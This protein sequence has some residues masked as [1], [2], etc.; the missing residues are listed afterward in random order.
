[1]QPI[2]KVNEGKYPMKDL[3]PSKNIIHS[4][5]FL[6]DVSYFYLPNLA[7]LL[8]KLQ[9]YEKKSKDVVKSW[10]RKK[11]EILLN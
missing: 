2:F 9:V 10:H 6:L 11:I 3:R 5:Q 1:M 7:T 4:F 8:L